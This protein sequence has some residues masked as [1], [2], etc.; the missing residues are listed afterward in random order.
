MAYERVRRPRFYIDAIQY[1]RAVGYLSETQNFSGE[2]YS[3]FT[4]EM[5]GLRPNTVWNTEFMPGWLNNPDIL[6]V[7]DGLVSYRT[8]L[9]IRLKNI[10]GLHNC[11]YFGC[12]NHNLRQSTTFIKPTLKHFKSDGTHVSEV[13]G[14]AG[15]HNEDSELS[16]LNFYNHTGD[17]WTSFDHTGG[18]FGGE[19]SGDDFS[20]HQFGSIV[21]VS[22]DDPGF[23]EGNDEIFDDDFSGE[24]D[25]VEDFDRTLVGTN[26]WGIVRF[27][28]KTTLDDNDY[29]GMFPSSYS[30]DIRHEDEDGITYTPNTISLELH[31]LGEGSLGDTSYGVVPQISAFSM[32]WT[33]TMEHAA[34]LSVEQTFS[35]D[36]VSREKGISGQNFSNIKYTKAPN[37]ETL[38]LYKDGGSSNPSIRT[39]PHWWRHSGVPNYGPVGA[40]EGRRE[41]TISFKYLS[42]STE[43]FGAYSMSRGLFPSTNHNWAHP[44]MFWSNADG[45]IGLK[46]NFIARIITG[47]LG[48]NL[49]FLFQPD[50][51]DDR[52]IFLCQFKEGGLSFTQSSSNVYDCQMTIE[53][54]W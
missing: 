5:Y 39:N 42:E 49:R 11:N 38:K 31:E 28:D 46:H 17:V 25:D 20:G 14:V 51:D 37:W 53:E 41:W 7:G 26:G 50:A 22:E 19:D 29:A 3:M 35:F 21:P 12:L 44:S 40:Y 27:N 52:E 6:D 47:T 43:S 45:W 10:L 1:L 13:Y 24:N 36:G 30:P 9:N 23:E 32:G 54:A 4:P 18:L 15:R 8:N 34:E 2:E 16:L 48:G 33:Y